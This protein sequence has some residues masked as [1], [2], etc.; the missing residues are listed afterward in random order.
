MRI[1]KVSI[2]GFKSFMD[3]ME[4]SVPEGISAVV[5]P[6]GCGKSNIVDA[7]RWAMGEQ[8]AKQL[9]GRQMEDVIFSG[10][11]EFK[12]MGMAEVSIL[13]EDGSGSF[14][15]E[16][17]QFTELAVTRRLY[18]SGESEYLINRVPCRLRD[19]QEIFMD[20]GLGSKAYS[21]IGQGRISSIIEQ[22]PEETRA[23]LEEAA[24]ITKY[25]KK[26][27]ESR[28][29]VEL[30]KTNLQR[31]ED[32][33]AEVERQMRSLKRQAAKA[34]RYK[35]LSEEIERLE[36]TLNANAYSELRGESEKTIRSTENLLQQEGVLASRFSARQTD[37]ERMN[38]ELAQM[39]E[40][41]D[42]LRNQFLSRKES[43]SRKESALESLA[44]EKR[45]QVALEQRL[46]DE[47]QD[48]DRRLRGLTEERVEIE[49]RV[50]VLRENAGALEGEMALLDQRLKKRNAVLEEIRIEYERARTDVNSGVTKEM[51]LNQE[52][53]YLN[54]R[55]GE[56]TDGRARLEQEKAEVAEKIERMVEASRRKTETREALAGKLAGIEEDLGL[57]RERRDEL[58]QVRRREEADLKKAETEL[59]NRDS[60][61][62]SLRSLTENFEGYKVGV[63]TIM[64]AKDL[65][66]RNQGR[67]FG[68]VADIIEVAPEFEQAVEAVLADR[69]QYIVVE[70]LE[71]GKEAVAYLKERARGRSS[72]VPLRHLRPNG[73]GSGAGN[74]L[75]LLR[76]RVSAPE[77]Y[78]PLIHTLLG[79]AVIAEDLDQ[80]IAVW[81]RNGIR[82]CLVT[83]DGDMIDERGVIS[84]G[85]VTQ[86]SHGLLARKREIFEL[87]Q[88]VAS[89]RKEVETL[90]ARLE[91]IDQDAQEKRARLESLELEREECREQIN[92]HDQAVLRFGHELDQLEKF[93]D[94]I[95]G[96]LEQKDKEKGKHQQ[97]LMRIEEELAACKERIR[98]NEVYLK[99][100]E[101]ELKESEE[102]AERFRS[103]LAQR[104]MDVNLAKEEEKGLLRQLERIDEYTDEA[105]EKLEK[106]GRDAGAA[107]KTFQDC[108]ER[109]KAVKEELAELRERLASAEETVNSADQERGS[110]KNRIREEEKEVG[111]IRGELDDLKERINRGRMQQSEITH[112]MNSLVEIV[113][114]KFNLELAEVYNQ[115][116]EEAFSSSETRDILEERKQYRE[117]LG[118]VNLAAIHEH[119]ELKERYAFITGQRDDLLNSIESL[120]KAIRKINR[121]CLEKFS[122]TFIEV[123]QKIREVFPILFKGGTA[124]LKLTDESRPLESGVLVE[125]RPP[126]KKLSHMGLLSGGEKALV[127]MA[128]LFAIYLIK[129][130]P[131]CL[132]DEVDAPLD[133][134]NLDRFN[135]LLGEI[136]KYSQVVLV[137][138]NRRSMEIAERLFGVTME[139]AGVSKLVSVNLSRSQLLA[140]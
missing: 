137:T 121:I 33:L 84:G 38:L 17:A 44:G 25:R 139:Q 31:V 138:H 71:D 125:V 12:P 97:D 67:V 130:S 55:I 95:T 108:E 34:K 1:K 69:L 27:D 48:L 101:T 26:V 112:R 91:Q 19:V 59:A 135:N 39:D 11:G 16:Y 129:P 63:R 8:S 74:G 107:R 40:E 133:E 77:A 52:S 111:T 102:E 83:P 92:E 119:E 96:E 100:K 113:R 136:R 2:V 46:G 20:T 131:F 56:I 21:I 116:V 37:V 117:K 94:R 60:R 134:A 114:D 89:G 45:M 81:S 86:S 51:G 73:N 104:K 50:A 36:L 15:G 30:T 64:K 93:S 128:L 53:G 103:E 78:R 68:L 118:E 9:R 123:D 28:R 57:E 140:A 105:R 85:K 14:P 35:A 88:Q 4:V 126:G 99:G 18:R 110:F 70:G 7:I 42:R 41:I 122:Q 13:F 90:I 80:A 127:A 6:N 5:G 82:Q 62:S 29:R 106:I 115:Y 49:E 10:A 3:R 23:M 47:K 61:L 76:D 132:L 120:N 72:F 54:Q 66:V 32:I 75:P 65:E 58:E 79:D 87:E 22:K 124:G 98:E 24:G 43:V 109:E